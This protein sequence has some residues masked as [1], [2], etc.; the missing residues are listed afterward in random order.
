MTVS[1]TWK[2]RTW[3]WHACQ[4]LSRAG[5]QEGRFASIWTGQQRT[6]LPVAQEVLRHI[7]IQ[8]LKT[9]MKKSVKYQW[10]YCGKYTE[11]CN[12]LLQL[13]F[14]IKVPPQVILYIDKKEQ[15]CSSV[16]SAENEENNGLCI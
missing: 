13:I 12:F 15:F 4:P 5:T 9:N 2:A 8:F 3:S 16:A 14:V 6:I 1:I 11:I 7:Q 10:I